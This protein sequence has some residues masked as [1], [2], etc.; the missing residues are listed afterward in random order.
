MTDVAV[1]P[2]A[3]GIAVGVVNESAEFVPDV[4]AFDDD[5]VAF[6]KI[7][8][9]RSEVDVVCDEQGLAGGKLED[10]ALVGYAFGIITE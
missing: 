10:E 2:L 3:I 5:S 4:F 1:E 9:A 7:L 6:L 8:N